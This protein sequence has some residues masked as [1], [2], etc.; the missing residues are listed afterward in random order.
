MNTISDNYLM[1]KVKNGDIDLMG[2]LF[3][4]YKRVLLGFFYN[5]LRDTSRSEDLLQTTF[6]K[7]IKYRAS[8]D[9]TKTFKTWIFT[10]A[11]N[12][13][14]DEQKKNS[15]MQ[16]FGL[17]GYENQLSEYNSGD[18]NLSTQDDQKFLTEILGKLSPEKVEVL[19]LVKL[20][21]K[22][23]SEVAAILNKKE[24]TVKSIVFRA[25]RELQAHL[26]QPNNYLQDGK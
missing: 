12:A 7:A 22:K 26:T 5:Q 18:L 17:E 3:E 16:K 14:K 21:N 11:R 23:Y 10:I 15:K 13:L 9:T 19:T 20:N 1:N 6:F 8:F 4:R 24:S 2:L 25:L